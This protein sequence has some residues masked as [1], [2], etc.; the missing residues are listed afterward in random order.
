MYLPLPPV[1]KRG[2]RIVGFDPSLRNWGI[3]KGIMIPGQKPQIHI[4]EVD[5][6]N[7]E[8]PTG[9]QVRQN[10]L[11]LESAKQLCSAA[12]AAAKGAQA[13]FVEVPVGSQSARA[14]ASYG[15]CVGVLG[16]LRATGIPFFEVTPT[17]V[18]MASVGKKTATKLDM[19]Q[20]AMARHPEANW[21]VYKQK[22]ET[23]VSEAKAEHMADATAAIY[24]GLS[25]NS[26]QQLL[27][28]M[29]P[30]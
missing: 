14:M 6:I 7:P 13:I 4:E 27:P 10:S 12:L 18:K 21:P 17:E 30:T 19:I 26:F 2:I 11:D 24:A 28:F 1:T 20:W 8:L 16:A 29:Q 15:I 5:V 22:G 9:K 23:K 25:C 3:S